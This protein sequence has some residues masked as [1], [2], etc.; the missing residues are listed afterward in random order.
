MKLQAEMREAEEAEEAARKAAEDAE[1]AKQ[2][3]KQEAERMKQALKEAMWAKLKA[4]QAEEV[5]RREA[6]K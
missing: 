4:A 5:A 3:Q 2:R 6:L 1:A